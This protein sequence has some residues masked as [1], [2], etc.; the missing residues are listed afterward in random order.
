MVYNRLS[1][2][3]CHSSLDRMALFGLMTT[4]ALGNC[5]GLPGISFFHSRQWDLLRRPSS[6]GFMLKEALRQSHPAVTQHQGLLARAR[7]VPPTSQWQ[8]G[9]LHAAAH[10]S[11]LLSATPVPS[12]PKRWPLPSSHPDRV[13]FCYFRCS[14]LILLC[15]AFKNKGAICK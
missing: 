2:T 6:Q 12:M 4:P 11:W 14:I 3:I 1:V 5:F 9:F 7:T 13:Q 10:I 15:E 8:L